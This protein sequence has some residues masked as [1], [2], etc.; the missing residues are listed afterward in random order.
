MT[1]AADITAYYADHTAALQPG[2]VLAG[3]PYAG[4]DFAS[5][6]GA[7]PNALDLYAPSGTAPGALPYFDSTSTTNTTQAQARSQAQAAPGFTL[8]SFD[9]SADP[10]NAGTLIF[11]GLLVIALILWE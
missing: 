8:T 9:S 6:T 2:Q 3:N 4:S 7:G 1:T 11:W 5:M 10:N